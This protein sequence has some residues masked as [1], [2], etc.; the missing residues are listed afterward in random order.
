MRLVALL[1][2]LT[3]TAGVGLLLLSGLPARADE[4]QDITKLVS[5]GQ[6]APALE[7][8]NAYLAAHP[9]DPQGRFIK[10]IVL[11]E[12]GKQTEAVQIFSALTEEYPEL[13]EP[14]NNLAV[15]YASQ[16]QYE[17][18]R[19]ALELAI[20]THPS[21]GTAHENL[22]DVYA[23]LATKS[24]DKALQLDKGNTSAQTKLSLIRSLFDKTATAGRPGS[25]AAQPETPVEKSVA[26]PTGDSTGKGAAAKP[27]AHDGDTDAVEVTVRA[28]A[29]AWSAKDPDAYL[30]FYGSD[31]RTP[32]GEKRQDWEKLR[33]ERL[34][35]PG[36]IQ[37]QLAD[38]SVSLADK[39]AAQVSFRQKY[40]S[41]NLK[42][43][44]QKTLLLR[45]NGDKWMIV[46][47]RVRG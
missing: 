23:K 28:W 30:A 43:T 33:R 47:E 34:T 19:N 24:Y 8:I 13:P 25:V 42:T 1:R 41:S 14:Y 4:L 12:Q 31:F 2:S 9:K 17:K 36:P 44:N 3:L 6:I 22:G 20:H 11:I 46:E 7:K 32:N 18:A 26:K 15:I 35:K 10:G 37:V 16:G 38:V 45:R 5:S 40:S 21:Y 27:T 39:D 29:A